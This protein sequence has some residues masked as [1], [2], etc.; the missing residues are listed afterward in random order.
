MTLRRGETVYT[1]LRHVS[2]S[3]MFRVIDLH[4]IRKNRPI[5][6]LAVLSD[7]QMERFLNHYKRSPDYNGFKTSG[8]GMDMGFDMVY[9]LSRICWPKGFVCIG[10]SDKYRKR[11][12]ANDHVNGDRDYSPHIHKDGGYCLRQEWV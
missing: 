12:P 1:T 10:D 7:K 2:R 9:N 5:N 6:I 11:C 3:G 4:I 8:C